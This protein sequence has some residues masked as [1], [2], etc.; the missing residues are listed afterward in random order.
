MLEVDALTILDLV[1]VGI[2]LPVGIVLSALIDVDLIAP[3]VGWQHVDLLRNLELLGL[4][5][6]LWHKLIQQRDQ[7][8]FQLLAHLAHLLHSRV[9]RRVVNYREQCAYLPLTL[10]DLSQVLRFDCLQQR[11]HVV[12]RIQLR[13]EP[14]ELVLNQRQQ[15]VLSLVDLPLEST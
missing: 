10:G 11:L 9:D 5:R 4:N 3:E 1:Q 15:I 2:V 13:E 12:K 7:L 8:I 14:L 6:I